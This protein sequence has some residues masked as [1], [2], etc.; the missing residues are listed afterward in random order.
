M[1][2]LDKAL[3]LSQNSLKVF[4]KVLGPEHLDVAKTQNKCACMQEQ[5]L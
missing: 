1:G 3:Q 5:I 2:E 4:E